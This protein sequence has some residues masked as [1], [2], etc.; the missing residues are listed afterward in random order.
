MDEFDVNQKL[1]NLQLKSGLVYHYTSADAI[2]KIIQ[3]DTLW[4]SEKGFLNDIS[5]FSYPL[6][7]RQELLAKCNELN[8]KDLLG[9]ADGIN[10]YKFYIFSLSTEADS[11][12][13]WS[14][15]CSCKGYCMG[16]DINELI[17]KFQ[18]GSIPFIHGKVIY[19]KKEQDALIQEEIDY[20]QEF[21]NDNNMFKRWNDE[22]EKIASAMASI[23]KLS[24][25]FKKPVY[26][27]EKEYRFVFAVRKKDGIVTKFRDKNGIIIPYIEI[28]KLNKLPIK[29]IIIGPKNDIDMA[30]H[31]IENL[32]Q[33]KLYE[34]VNMMESE[35]TLRY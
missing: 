19:D 25:F 18:A 9:F 35:A 15:Y 4:V 30:K 12:P 1:N 23:E 24:H 10:K 27:S 20:V 31:G 28:D 14:E 26:Y 34:N 7:I 16:L 2:S 6:S 33:S 8:K 13:L 32:L 21:I 3:N 22:M 17:D 5:E 11:M 29:E